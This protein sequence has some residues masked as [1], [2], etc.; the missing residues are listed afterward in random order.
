VRSRLINFRTLVGL[1]IFDGRRM[2]G[3]VLNVESR[4][5]G[6]IDIL[7]LSLARVD[8]TLMGLNVESDVLLIVTDITGLL[9]ELSVG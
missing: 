5:E 7:E 9:K 1:V 8:A 4:R 6:V 3:R 2:A